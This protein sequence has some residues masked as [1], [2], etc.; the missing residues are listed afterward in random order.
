MDKWIKEVAEKGFYHYIMYGENNMRKKSTG[1]K[2]TEK[3][4]EFRT[5]EGIE[6]VARKHAADSCRCEGVEITPESHD[7]A[8]RIISK[9]KTHQPSS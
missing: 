2:V 7:R 5:E 9:S 4:R 6:R 1:K 8:C 3:V